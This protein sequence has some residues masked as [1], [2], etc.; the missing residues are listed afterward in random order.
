MAFLLYEFIVNMPSRWSLLSPFHQP[1]VA[2][3]VFKS[4]S[5]AFNPT[6]FP[7]THITY[8]LVSKFPSFCLFLPFPEKNFTSLIFNYYSTCSWTPFD[9]ILPIT[10]APLCSIDQ[11]LRRLGL[12]GRR[13]AYH[14]MG[15]CGWG[16]GK[17][18][19]MY[20]SNFKP[21]SGDPDR[22]GQSIGS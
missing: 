8:P 21:S 4:S 10:Y 9:P 2:V 1:L 18:K 19:R 7:T 6:P 20:S 22:G 12:G 15:R 16:N 17:W 14:N 11:D 3:A 13:I 5:L